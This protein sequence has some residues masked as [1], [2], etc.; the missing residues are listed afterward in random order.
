MTVL[1]INPS[2]DWQ[3]FSYNMNNLE[4]LDTP[5]DANKTEILVLTIVQSGGVAPTEFDIDFITFTI[6]EPF[7]GNE[8]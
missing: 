3:R 5:F 1:L 7:W 6:D 2:N 8:K 4:V